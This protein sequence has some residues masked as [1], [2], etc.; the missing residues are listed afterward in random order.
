M[1]RPAVWPS[2]TNIFVPFSLKPSP[3]GVASMV[4]P[5][6]SHLP[7]SSVKARVAMSSPEAICGRNSFLAASS[8]ACRRVLVARA[9]VEKYGAQRRRRPIS[10]STTVSST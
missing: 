7:D 6:S 1:I 9:T 8:P 2:S 10:S 4:M 3:A 5:L